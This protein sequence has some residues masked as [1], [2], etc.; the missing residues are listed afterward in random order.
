MI[1]IIPVQWNGE[2]LLIGDAQKAQNW[3][4]HTPV[5]GPLGMF[6]ASEEGLL[7]PFRFDDGHHRV[8]RFDWNGK[9]WAASKMGPPFVVNEHEMEPSI[10]RQG[11][12]YFSSFRGYV[13]PK[14]RMYVSDDQLNYKFLFDWDSVQ[15]SPMV[16][17]QGLD[18]SLYLV[19]NRNRGWYRNPLMAYPIEGNALGDGVIIHDQDGV[20]DDKGDKLPFIDHGRGNNVLL[21]GRWRHLLCYRVCDL[22]E[23]TLYG[24]QQSVVKK[25]YGDTG[26]FPN[27]PL[28]ACTSRN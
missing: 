20:R 1:E 23:R 25:I 28:P 12:R 3:L 16:L 8:V 18:G 22:K 17:N 24:F 10:Q 5:D 27:A 15:D 6:C 11:T 2:K 7:A 9:A 13:G 19:T 4:G 21:E 26:P 14:N